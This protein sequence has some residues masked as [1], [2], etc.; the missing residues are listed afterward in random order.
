MYLIYILLSMCYFVGATCDFDFDKIG[1]K[2][3][4][5]DGIAMTKTG[6]EIKIEMTNDYYV[7]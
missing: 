6:N 5:L 7:Y 1:F 4:G 3:G 2:N